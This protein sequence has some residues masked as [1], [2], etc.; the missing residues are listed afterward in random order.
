MFKNLVYLF[1]LMGWVLINPLVLS[2]QS[3][4]DKGLIITE[5]E[6]NLAF[7]LAKQGFSAPLYV[8]DAD[9][10]V[11]KI[12]AEAFKN[13]I[14]LLTGQRPILRNQQQEL[15]SFPV[16]IGTIGQSKY[17][18]QWIKTKQIDAT[19]IKGQWERFAIMVVQ[20]PQKGIK[21]A[22]VIMGSDRR[23]TAFG[24]FE[25]SRMMGVSPWYW[26][27]DVLPK[28]KK[29]IYISPGNLLSHPPSVKYRGIFINDEDWGLHPWAAKNIDKTLKDIGPKTY[30]KVFE[31]LLRLK[32]NYIWPAM[33]PCTKAFYFYADNP[34]LADDYAIVVGSSHCEPM[35][36]NNVFEWAANFQHEYG[37]QPGAWRYDVNKA[38]INQYWKDRI[39]QSKK[40]ESVYTVGMR[41]IHDG[42]MP[43]P[44]DKALKV[45]LLG[46]VIAA[47]DSILSEQ[48]GKPSSAI[49]QIFCPYKE[50]LSLYQSGLILPDF[51]T[52]VWSD[53]NHGYIRQLANDNEQKRSGRSGVYYHLSY[54][55]AP[56]DYLWLSSI[57]PVLISYELSKAYQYQADQVWVINVGDIKPAEMELQ[58]TMDLAWN[59]QSWPPEKAH[60][61]AEKWAEETFGKDFALPIAQIK[62]TYYRLAQEAKPEH[63]NLVKF[64]DAQI[65]ERLKAYETIFNEVQALKAKIPERLQ[66]AYFQL[67]AYP[68]EGAYLMNQKIFYAQKSLQLAQMAD[69]NAFLYAQKAKQ[70]FQ[71]IGLITQKYNHEI[72]GGKWN[73]IMSDHPRDLEVFKMPAVAETWVAPV[74]KMPSKNDVAVL[75]VLKAS[76]YTTQYAPPGYQIT[77]ILGLGIGGSG[78]SVLPFTQKPLAE[79]QLSE[80]AYAVYAYDFKSAGTYTITIKALPTQG[81]NSG[82]KVRY[83]I[84]VGD[85]MPQMVN[86]APEGENALWKQNVLRGYASGITKHQIV[87]K[88]KQQIKIY[89]L[90][91]GTVINQLSFLPS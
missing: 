79:N 86:L 45:K 84:A 14:Q 74:Q 37:T 27:A 65:T 80:A 53:D 24:V 6:S 4:Q 28:P 91:P 87:K 21:N 22:L 25:L 29:S 31:L 26:W 67:I 38:Q 17:I 90:D 68:V 59:I 40:Y 71:Q 77:K 30:A 52:T 5:K 13:D 9:A 11:V 76:D 42:S 70:A 2:A 34:K 78:I 51:V 33:H 62:A 36:R 10:K 20:H 56:H 12:A 73:G 88:G 72:A 35:L 46:E 61:F 23:G 7:P 82:I 63:L 43:G 57:S 16:I 54:W 60:R 89:F 15:Q 3:R 58:F 39:K 8:D 41:G 50:V 75:D 81:V 1:I 55:G 83:A 85:E 64:T 69:S 47:Q 18:D 44:K 32:A 19:P 48:I 66:A 49:P